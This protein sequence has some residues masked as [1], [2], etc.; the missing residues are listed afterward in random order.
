M[1]LPE[2]IRELFRRAGRQ[3][4]KK[5]AAQMTPEQRRAR[6]KKASEAVPL[7]QRAERSRKGALAREENRKKAARTK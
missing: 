3:G 6:A 7:E 5:A 4:G 2:E 1:R